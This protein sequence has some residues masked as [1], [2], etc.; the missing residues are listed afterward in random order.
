MLLVL[1]INGVLCCKVPSGGNIK[2]RSY[3]VKFRPYVKE[4]L[5]YAYKNFNVAFFSSTTE[6]NARMI[7]NAL[8]DEEQREK[9]VFYWF[10][11]KTKKDEELGGHETIKLASDVKQEYGERILI[12]DDSA[13]KMRFNDPKDYIICKSY[14]GSD[15]SSVLLELIE[16]LK[17]YEISLNIDI[18]N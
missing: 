16:Q 10:R 13:S 11:D 9:T 18:E 6:P 14:D 1:D 15:D 12:I 5:N 3:E 8:L 17:M 7:L 4:F 2:L